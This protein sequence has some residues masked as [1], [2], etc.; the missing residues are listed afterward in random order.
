ML[1]DE[2]AIIGHAATPPDTRICIS[3]ASSLEAGDM[4]HIGKRGF[5]LLFFGRNG[6]LLG[7]VSCHF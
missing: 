5:V 3:P 6:L 1:A 4:M 2:T 7:A